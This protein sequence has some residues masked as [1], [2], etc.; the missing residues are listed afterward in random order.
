MIKRYDGTF[1]SMR[2][3]G[4]I[5]VSITSIQHGNILLSF[6]FGYC[7]DDTIS[8]DIAVIISSTVIISLICANR[9]IDNVNDV[10]GIGSPRKTFVGPSCSVIIVLYLLNLRIPQDNINMDIISTACW[11]YNSYNTIAGD[12]PNDIASASESIVSPNTAFVEFGNFLDRGPSIASNIT[13]SIS[14]AAVRIIL[15]LITA[16]IA[17]IPDIAFKRE[18]MS[19]IPI[20]FIILVCIPDHILIIDIY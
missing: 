10:T 4:Y 11:S 2:F 1:M 18:A 12:S 3:I 15:S 13:A 19:A 7:N 16:T 8:T 5:K 14:S 20:I 17:S 9:S 6:I